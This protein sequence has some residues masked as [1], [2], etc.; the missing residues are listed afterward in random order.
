MTLLS[1]LW[2]AGA[3]VLGSLTFGLFVG[4]WVK[5]IDIRRHGSGNLGAT[6][7]FRVIGWKWGIL[8][9]FLDTLKGFL[10]VGIPQIAFHTD[11]PSYFLLLLGHTFPLWLGFKGG[12]GVATSLGVFLGIAPLP[13]LFAFGLWVLV[14]ASFRIL[15]LASL[16]AAFAFPIILALLD[17]RGESFAYLFPVACLLTLFIA[18]L[19]RENIRRIFRGEEKRLF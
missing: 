13:T 17:R 5:G 16:I 2:A 3:Y 1:L 7:V 10:A 18:Y 11:F 19:H 14:F 4:R 15:S 9:L 12:K 8:V 6:N